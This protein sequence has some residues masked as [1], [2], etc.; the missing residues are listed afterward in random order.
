MFNITQYSYY[1]NGLIHVQTNPDNSTTTYIY[2]NNGNALSV[3]NS[4]TGTTTYTY[5]N[6]GWELSELTL[7]GNATNY[8]YDNDKNV[9]KAT[10]NNSV[11]RSI[12]DG[13][14][15]KLIQEIYPSQYDS[16]KDGLNDATPTNTYRDSSVGDRNTYDQRGNVSTHIDSE[17]NETDFTYDYNNKVTKQVYTYSGAQTSQTTRYVYGYY[18]DQEMLTQQINPDQYSSAYDVLTF[19]TNTYSD[20]TVGDRYTYDTNGNMLTHTDPANKVTSYTYDNAGNRLTS[21]HPDGSVF[22]YDSTGKIV[23]EKYADGRTNTTNYNTDGTLSGVSNT[24]NHSTSYGYDSNSNVNQ[25]TETFGSNVKSTSYTYDANGNILTVSVGGLLQVTYTY[26]ANNQLTREDNVNQNQ[27]IVYAYD[28]NGNMTTKT[29][30]PYATGTLGTATTTNT[31]GY[32]QDGKNQLTSFNGNAITYDTN[33]NMQTYNGWTYTWQN[34]TLTGASNADNTISYQYND[35]NIRTSKTVNGVTTNY[36]LDSN[37]NVTS[38]TNGTDTIDYTYDSNGSLVYMTLNGTIYY[39]EKNLQGDIIG[40]VDSNNNEVVTYTYDSWGKLL[41]IG[42]SLASTVGVMNPYRYRGYRYD[43]ETGMYYLQS[44][45]YNPDIGRFISKDDPSF[46]QG[47]NAV[48]VNLYAY[49][50]NDVVMYFDP[51]GSIL[52]LNGTTTTINSIVGLLDQLDDGLICVKA[53]LAQRLCGPSRYSLSDQLLSDIISSKYT[54]TINIISGS[55]PNNQ[56][57]GT[58]P[59][60]NPTITFYTVFNP[61]IYT[62][63]GSIIAPLFV[64]LA[65]ELIHAWRRMSGVID[66]ITMTSYVV[67]KKTYYAPYE[68]LQTVGIAGTYWVTEQKIEKEHGLS[69]RLIY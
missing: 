61:T 22:T 20:S 46:D 64:V 65:H 18:N 7:S 69:I 31:Y 52:K 37:N 51:T 19:N 26:D 8:V 3:T 57:P 67:N 60:V 47:T 43:T 68:E 28:T 35:N 44:R 6:I 14:S 9:I 42:G 11:T 13:T 32:S 59:N 38:E 54:C 66:N 36:T 4:T 49:C 63:N 30:Y 16:T 34:T 15:G 5:N 41:S 55:P 10:V 62:N 50:G 17:G 24:N 56:G 23:T 33:G 58:S 2:D 21:T 25:F 1:A 12:Y 27:S 39:Y 40:L 48:S 29:I 45:Y 53:N